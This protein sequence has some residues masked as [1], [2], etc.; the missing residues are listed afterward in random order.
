MDVDIFTDKNDAMK[1]HSW[2]RMEYYIGDKVGQLF[3]GGLHGPESR[4][5]NL[6]GDPGALRD[7]RRAGL[8]NR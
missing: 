4:P 6:K 3:G 2:L 1:W 8:Q 7:E 5:I